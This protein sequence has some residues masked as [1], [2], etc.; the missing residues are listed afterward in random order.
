MTT[1]LD[2]VQ[3][4]APIMRTRPTSTSA[5]VLNALFLGT[6]TNEESDANLAA[7]D[8]AWNESFARNPAALKRLADR[9]RQQV[10]EGRTRPLRVEDL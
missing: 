10:A 7:E 4:S 8:T 1:T 2:R 6:T 5:A 3:T 9:A